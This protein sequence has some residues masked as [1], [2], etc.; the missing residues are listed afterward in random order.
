ML[1]KIGTVMS[2]FGISKLD[3]FL[4]VLAL[5]TAQHET[6][7]A[8]VFITSRLLY[9]RIMVVTVTHSPSVFCLKVYMNLDEPN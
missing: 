9:N 6:E 2:V 5:V 7:T 1:T 3:S 4:Q 8:L